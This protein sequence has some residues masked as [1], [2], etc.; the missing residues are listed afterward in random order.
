MGQ[1]RKC[2]QTVKA[3]AK[4]LRQRHS[5]LW[6]EYQGH[7]GWNSMGKEETEAGKGGQRKDAAW[8]RPCRGEKVL[9]GS[10]TMN[11]IFGDRGPVEYT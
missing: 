10:V 1:L 7:C 8:S 9:E 5:W 3:N 4:V 2:T 6:E 11:S